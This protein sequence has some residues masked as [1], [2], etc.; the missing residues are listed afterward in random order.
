MRRF[1][2]TARTL[3][4][5]LARGA[6][7]GAVVAVVDE[8]ELL[9]LRSFGRA[10][11][12]PHPA[13]ATVST[14]YD[15]A[16][17]T[18]VLCTT[19]LCMMAVEEGALDLEARVAEWVPEFL[20]R[21]RRAVRL[22]HLLAHCSGLPAHR[23]YYEDS[24]G[25]DAVFDRAVAEPLEYPAG[26]RT[27]YSDIG[28]LVLGRALERAMRDRVDHLFAAR[29]AAPLGLRHTRFV[30]LARPGVRAAFLRHH[31][32]APTQVRGGAPRVGAVDDDNALAMEGIAPHAG[33]FGPA[34][35]VA[36]VGTALCRAWQSG[37]LTGREVTRRF[38]R[39]AGVAGSTRALGWD[40]PSP[41]GSS[42]GQRFPRGA[43]GQLGYTGGSIWMAPA[44]GLVVVLLTNRVHPRAD[45]DAIKSV[46]PAVHDAVMQDLDG[47][48]R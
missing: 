1:A 41:E 45:N 12:L 15:L 5:A 29:I 33:L 8:G 20:G 3:E 17:L 30:D 43:V 31:A 10:A 18:K 42:A 6:F 46:R 16:S 26:R 14:V 40:T 4:R 11:M 47:S 35:E 27:V 13:A 44:R 48:R 21:G 24:R 28:F 38:L 23:R 32:V 22:W 7:P 25:R 2:H 37:G 36:S 34:I 39:R 9:L 19:T